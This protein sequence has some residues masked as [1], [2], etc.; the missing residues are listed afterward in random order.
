MTSM[1]DLSVEV[2]SHILSYCHSSMRSLR[3]VN[4]FFFS[5]V[6]KYLIN[7][8]HIG[9]VGLKSNPPNEVTRRINIYSRMS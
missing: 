2:M 6:G 9:E 8:V 7:V 4:G 3:L 5:L 1:N